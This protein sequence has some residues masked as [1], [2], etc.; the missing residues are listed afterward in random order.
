M[1]KVEWLAI[2]LVAIILFAACSK[3]STYVGSKHPPFDNSVAGTTI[4]TTQ[5]TN[6]YETVWIPK[7]G[8][9]YHANARCCGM[10]NPSKVTI[11]QAR[12]M[13]YTACSNC[14]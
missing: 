4:E 8:E 10:D 14:W 11:T 7:T 1:K 9:K 2:L 5:S 12:N 3:E 6:G 13:G